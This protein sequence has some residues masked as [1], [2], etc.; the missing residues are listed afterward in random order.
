LFLATVIARILAHLQRRSAEQLQVELPLGARAPPV[1]PVLVSTR[2]QGVTALAAC[3]AGSGRCVP[4][5]GQGQGPGNGGQ[6][7]APG[8]GFSHRANQPG[9]ER[10]FEITVRPHLLLYSPPQNL[11]VSSL[12]GPCGRASETP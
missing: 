4:G 6:G 9:R 11:K 8:A 1:Q 10:W 12:G 7:R 2:R 5:A 3:A